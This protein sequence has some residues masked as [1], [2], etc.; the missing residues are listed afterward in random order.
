MKRLCSDSRLAD[1]NVTVL[2]LPHVLDMGRSDCLLWWCCIAADSNGSHPGARGH[3]VL[4][5]TMGPLHREPGPVCLDHIQIWASQSGNCAPG[6]GLELP[7]A[8][9]E[10]SKPNAYHAVWQI[11]CSMT[12]K[13]EIWEICVAIAC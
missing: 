6:S 12:Y 11:A 4:P 13:L 1:S 7:E 5:A 3:A 8:A 9:Q 2:A 10:W